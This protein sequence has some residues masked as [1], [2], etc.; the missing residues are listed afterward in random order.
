MRVFMENKVTPFTLVSMIKN[1]GPSN[2]KFEAA[3]DSSSKKY[4]RQLSKKNI[5]IIEECVREEAIFNLILDRMSRTQ[6]GYSLVL[7]HKE[8]NILDFAFKKFRESMLSQPNCNISVYDN[9]YQQL[10]LIIND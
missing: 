10:L 9:A 2:T 1:S 6:S 4:C 7:G 5:H 8:K 3:L